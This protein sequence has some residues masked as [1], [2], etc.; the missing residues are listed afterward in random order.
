[1]LYWVRPARRQGILLLVMHPQSLL[2]QPA[3]P[4]DWSDPRLRRH[5]V[6]F[7]DARKGGAEW[8]R[9]MAALLR[10]TTCPGAPVGLLVLLARVY[11]KR[12]QY[13]QAY[14]CLQDVVKRVPGLQEAR[15]IMGVVCFCMK[16]FEEARV[17]LQIA[18]SLNPRDEIAWGRLA[19]CFDTQGK[20]APT[21]ACVLRQ[22]EINPGNA[23]ARRHLA[24]LDGE[25]GAQ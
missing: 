13:E 23:G 12:W 2:I 19:I 15:S 3:E 1:M 10:D 11:V 4:I 8:K 21:R 25:E 14:A 5:C 24:M 20:H 6:A 17:H 9:G 7:R 18:I 16:R 22:L